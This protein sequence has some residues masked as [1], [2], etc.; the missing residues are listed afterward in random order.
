[1]SD[2][3]NLLGEDS[4][5][6]EGEAEDHYFTPP[7]QRKL[8]T[9]DDIQGLTAL[10][11]KKG[12]SSPTDKT[13][14]KWSAREREGSPV[15]HRLSLAGSSFGRK[16]DG[17]STST[18]AQQDYWSASY[19][20]AS[21]SGTSQQQS[22]PSV[23]PKRLYK[24]Q[25]QRERADSAIPQDYPSSIG[26][27]YGQ[28]SSSSLQ[29]EPEVSRKVRPRP[30]PL[31]IPQ[32]SS[33]TAIPKHVSTPS[34]EI[35]REL[36]DPL[37]GGPD[38]RTMRHRAYPVPYQTPEA[39]GYELAARSRQEM[40]RIYK[41]PHQKKKR[42]NKLLT[43]RGFQYDR[44]S[45]R[46]STASG[47]DD[48]SDV[49]EYSER[50][51][52]IPSRER[53]ESAL[54][55]PR[56]YQPLKMMGNRPRS[57]IMPVGSLGFGRL[58]PDHRSKWQSLDELRI[59]DVEED[60]AQWNP[61]EQAFALRLRSL[62]ESDL[63]AYQ[64]YRNMADPRF[65]PPARRRMIPAP[66]GTNLMDF[67]KRYLSRLRQSTRHSD[68]QMARRASVGSRATLTSAIQPETEQTF[69]LSTLSE[70]SPLLMK[71]KKKKKSIKKKIKDKCVIQ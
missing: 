48:G 46:Y 12:L 23:R 51:H 34:P 41:W 28:T 53:D 44:Q 58:D 70:T 35:V 57:D 64:D 56:Y 61:R 36:R 40:D 26:L 27:R 21:T 33:R 45:K 37:S 10:G 3:K 60:P 47:S 52:L 54:I 7:Q 71:T 49:S 62:S 50:R 16:D 11:S 43:D 66:T 67:D 9:W 15:K 6:D 17:V 65:N 8:Y 22:E 68:T 19:G 38:W 59:P 25:H 5:F 31:H 18:D 1:M 63:N 30:P 32:S 13:P 69:P 4:D 55:N 29:S 20:G 42:K 14:V 24:A 2:K 39:Q